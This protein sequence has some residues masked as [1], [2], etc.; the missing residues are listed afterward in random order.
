MGDL[1]SDLENVRAH[2]DNLL[3]ITKGNWERHLAKLDEVLTKLS[4]A[5][6]KPGRH[7]AIK[8][9]GRSSIENR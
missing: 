6:L 4:K 9:E 2:I 5:G 8:E 3:V 7:P 1:F